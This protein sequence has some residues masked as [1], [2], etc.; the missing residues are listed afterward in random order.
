MMGSK[1]FCCHQNAFKR[2]NLVYFPNDRNLVHF[3][4][5]LAPAALNCIYVE[6][7][8][9]MSAFQPTGWLLRGLIR[10]PKYMRAQTSFQRRVLVSILE[11]FSND[12]RKSKTKAIRAVFK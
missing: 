4:L 12:C 8:V 1:L 7:F 6:W 10:I 11:R 3:F 9:C 5:R 2:N